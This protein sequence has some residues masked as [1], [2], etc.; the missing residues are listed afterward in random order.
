LRFNVPF[1]V[2][3]IAPLSR[4]RSYRIRVD[5]LSDIIQLQAKADSYLK[6][7][8]YSANELVG[9]EASRD[10]CLARGRRQVHSAFHNEEM[11]GRGRGFAMPRFLIDIA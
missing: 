6:E 7:S 3:E 11:G 4:I 9:R 5:I 2:L 1:L 8:E 10:W